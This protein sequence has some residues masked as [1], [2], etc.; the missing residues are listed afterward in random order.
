M[1]LA[2][3]SHA[4][5]RAVNRKVYAL[6][7]A[8]G[9]DVIILAPT[10]IRGGTPD[11]QEP[12]SPEV[13][14][15]PLSSENPRTYRFEGAAA[16]LDAF[17]PDAVIVEADPLSLITISTSAWCRRHGARLMCLSVENLDF[18]P[19]PH[20]LRTGARS[21]P[22][23]A[24]K[25]LLNLRARAVVDEVFTISQAGTALFKRKGYR[26]VTQ[27][28][29]GFDPAVFHPDPAARSRIRSSLGL[30]DDVPVLG[31]FGRVTRQKGVHLIIEALGRVA[32]SAP[33]AR[34]LLLMDRFQSDDAYVTKLKQQIERSGLAPRIAFF[35]ADHQEIAGFMAAADAV[36]LASLTT[37]TSLEQYGRVIPEAMACGALAIV[38]D[39]GAP[40]ELVGD[41]GLVLPE[42]SLDGLA[43]TLA[44]VIERL[45]SYRALAERGRERAHALLSVSR[46]AA[47]YRERLGAIVGEPR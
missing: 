23:I 22:Q 43:A 24:A 2:V 26:S 16:V 1:R 28:P 42:G 36:V 17:K 29:L 40:K 35:D 39:C 14:F 12:D 7:A 18:G 34:W 38:S 3:L 13:H 47:I 37:P 15:L 32:D 33:S 9:V 11:P 25:N 31:Y 44:D 27:V 5:F 6:L 4:C 30:A 8:D 45:P 20:L 21:L 10:A 46:Q 19:I 41:C